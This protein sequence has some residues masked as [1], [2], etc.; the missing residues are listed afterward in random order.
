MSAAANGGQAPATPA[1]VPGP[2]GN[3]PPAD[4][5]MLEDQGSDDEDENP[6]GR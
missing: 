3:T 1:A 5:E 2:N 6:A 4:D